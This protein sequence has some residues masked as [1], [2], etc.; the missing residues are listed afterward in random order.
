MEN[1]QA[2]GVQVVGIDGPESAGGDAAACGRGNPLTADEQALSSIA[3]RQIYNELC[4]ACHG[5]DG[6]GTPKPEPPRRWRR[7]WPVRR[8]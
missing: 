4:V 2:R 6:F 5:P 8:A 1:N 7:R 3:A